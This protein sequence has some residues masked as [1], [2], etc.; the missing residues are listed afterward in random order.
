VIGQTIS[1]YKITEKLGEGGMG[2]VYLAEDTSLKRKVA[3]KFL[4]DYLQQD[5]VAQKRFLREARS[6]A[7]LDHPYICNIHEV[8]ETEG[9]SFIVMEYVKGQTLKEKLLE[10]PVPLK[11]TLQIGVEIAEALEEA[12]KAGIAHRD[13]KP[14]NIMLTSGGHVKVMDF[15]LA[16]KVVDEDGTEQDITS[17]LTREGTT[18]G[19]IAY[20]SP[21]QLRGKTVDTRSDIFSFGIVLYELLSGVHPFRKKRQAETTAAILTEEPESL[22]RYTEDS[23]EILQHTI[24]KMLEKEP[25]DRYQSVHEVRTNLRRPFDRLTVAEGPSSFLARKP[26]IP[27]AGR[28][29]YWALGMIAIV[30]LFLG[31]FFLSTRHE[32]PSV[33]NPVPL[34]S[35]GKT[36]FMHSLATDGRTIYYCETDHSYF[37]HHGIIKQISVD[38][39]EAVAIDPWPEE[40]RLTVLMDVSP[41]HSELLVGS[42][43]SDEVDLYFTGM[44]LWILSLPAGTPKRLGNLVATTARWSPDGKQIAYSSRNVLYVGERDGTGFEEILT[45]EKVLLAWS[46]SPDGQR[47]CYGIGDSA[48]QSCELWE[49]AVDGSNPHQLFPAEG[50]LIWSFGARWTPDG[51]WLLFRVGVGRWSNLWALRAQ[52]NLFDLG[53]KDPVQ[54][55]SRLQRYLAFSCSPQD[56]RIFALCEPLQAELVRYREEIQDWVRYDFPA[57]EAA[58]FVEHSPDSTWV[59]YVDYPGYTLWSCRTDGKQRSQLTKTGLY[60]HSVSW[61]PDSGKIAFIGGTN[62]WGRRD[63][64]YVIDKQGGEPQRVTEKDYLQVTASWSPKGELV[65]SGARSGLEPLRLVDLDTGKVEEIPRSEGMWECA[66]SRDG[67][68]IASHRA[69]SALIVLFDVTNQQWIELNACRGS[70]LSWSEDGRHLYFYHEKK[71]F[72]VS[73]EEFAVEEVADFNNVAIG[74]L[75]SL[76]PNQWWYGFDR[77]GSLITLRPLGTTEI[78]ALDFEAP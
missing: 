53:P 50:E 61:S 78:Y 41:A 49:V 34:T 16:K 69:D 6:A 59:A 15:G 43:T 21:E 28:W 30:A 19:T 45:A 31:V 64:A 44:P 20:M 36:K 17:A 22:S 75:A 46:W 68:F 26:S 39:G 72:R 51:E 14:A 5:E 25:D 63:R 3:L 70:R 67:R 62:I 47:L 76:D 52:E 60:V 48:K 33:K 24:T 38:G 18:L 57:T 42:A 4:P 2:E 11:Q 35:D 54:L 9:R 73:V 32:I 10:G 66:W 71:L 55:T 40:E 58:L 8:G 29:A 56:K 65:V 23:S 37:P 13:L 12:H 1:H 7:A 27:G 77:E 74:P